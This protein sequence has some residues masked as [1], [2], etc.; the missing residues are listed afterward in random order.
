MSVT[1][2]AS[3]SRPLVGSLT[4]GMKEMQMVRMDVYFAPKAPEGEKREL[5]ANCSG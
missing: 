4:K 1:N 5:A 3:C 2:K